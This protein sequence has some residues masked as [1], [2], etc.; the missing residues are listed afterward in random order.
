[1]T[2]DPIAVPEKITE[3][4][5]EK[6]GEKKHRSTLKII[7]VLFVFA[8]I[9][10]GAYWTY[11]EGKELFDDKQAAPGQQTA[12]KPVQPIAAGLQP[13]AVPTE[14]ADDMEEPM[15]IMVS[16]LPPLIADAAIPRLNDG[17]EPKPDDTAQKQAERLAQ[18]M[19]NNNKELVLYLAARDLRDSI[20]RPERFKKEL[21]FV[22]AVSIDFPELQSKIELLDIAADEG[23]ATRLTLLG[24]LAKLRETLRNKNHGS[25]IAN[26]QNSLSRLVTITKIEGD[27]KNNDFNSIIKRAEI[28]VQKDDFQL[29]AKEL[30]KLGADAKPVLEKISNINNVDEIV[31]YII[32][33]AKS[34]IASE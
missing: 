33:F 5:A 8:F 4:K 25:F 10:G 18:Q 16:P 31:E 1:M 13:A 15:E 6:A 23:I 34:K 28:A 32:D 14:T 27:V 21:S 22:R 2:E 7:L 20:N 24:E 19:N 26:L 11:L 3:I 29:A 9:F 30:E 17:T 12:N